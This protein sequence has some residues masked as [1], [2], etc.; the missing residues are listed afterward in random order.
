MTDV[1][2]SYSRKD[3]Q[4]VQVL[5]Q[6]L[7][8]S[9]YDAWVDW[10]NIPLTADWWE[11]IKA[12]IEGADTFIF[13]IS[14]DS[15][16]SKVCGQEIDHAVE[17][18][19]RLLPIVY[20]EG[21]D[22][23]LVRSALG[24]HNWLFFRDE[25]DFDTT[26]QLLVD[27]LNTDLAHVKTHTQLLVK[28]LEW[29]HKERN[30]DLLLRG[31]QLES[32]LS[33]ITANADKEPRLTQEQ[34]EYVAASSQTEKTSQEA[35][36][37]RQQQEL[38]R[39][40]RWLGL[41]GIAF[42]IAS[43]LGIL[44]FSQFRVAEA[45]RQEVE[46]REIET[47]ATSAEAQLNSNQGL[48]GLVYGL[49]AARKLE[50][51]NDVP[52]KTEYRVIAALQQALRKAPERNRIVGH[53]DH[54]WYAALSPD[55]QYIVSSGRDNIANLWTLDGKKVATFE[56]HTAPVSWVAISPDNQTFATASGDA[57]I[58]LWNQA[59]ELLKTLTKHD[60]SVRNVDFSPDGKQLVSA[61]IDGTI[62]LWDV[63]GN[64]LTSS[65][66]SDAVCHALFSPNGQSLLTS[67]CGPEAQLRKPSG[68]MI[69]TLLGH[70]SA[71]RRGV[72]SPDGQLIAT[73]SRTGVI[74][75]WNPQGDELASIQAHPQDMW[76]LSFS[77]DSQKI[78]S[79]G[80]DGSFKVWSIDGELL[81]SFDTT[82]AISSID[83][84]H[85]G[86]TLL[87]GDRGGAVR[88]WKPK[89]Q[90][91]RQN[92]VVQ[93][94]SFSPDG[95]TFV[96]ASGGDD[97]TVKLWTLEGTLLKM[98]QD[99]T[100]PVVWA[101][102]TPDGNAVTVGDGS[103]TA[104]TLAIENGEAIA[105]WAKDLTDI[106]MVSFSPDSKTMAR[107]SI[108][109]TVELRSTSGE[110]STSFTA[111]D[112]RI[113]EATFSP[114]GTKL[115][116]ASDDKTVKVWSMKGNLLV[117]LIGHQSPVRG[118]VFSPDGER[119]ASVSDDRTVKLWTLTGEELVT[120]RGHRSNVFTVAFSPDGQT[121]ASGSKD[122]TIRLWTTDGEELAIL[123][124]HDSAINS[125]SFSPDGRT[126]ASADENGKTLLW[127]L[128]FDD[129]LVQTCHE[130]R[131]YL[132][133]SVNLTKRDRALCNGVKRDW[134]AEG[135]TLARQGKLEA[136]VSKF[137]QALQHDA[138]LT[139]DPL[140]KA[141]QIAASIPLNQAE[142]YVANRDLSSATEAYKQ[143]LA[144][145]PELN[146]EPAVRAR[147]E[148]VRSLT[149]KMQTLVSEGLT[150]EA[151]IE[152]TISVFNQGREFD[153]NQT[154]QARIL[155]SI[156]WEG[157]LQG[158][159]SKL[160]DVCEEA[161]ALAPDHGGI[162][163]SRGLARALTGDTEGAISDFQYFIDWTPDDNWSI[164]EDVKK[165]RQQWIEALQRGENPFTPEVLRNLLHAE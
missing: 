164:G 111:H 29:Q 18:N 148:I 19:K 94:V 52:L 69:T 100:A 95:Q 41:V 62:K 127:N 121:I 92:A 124:G 79:S 60:G 118:V 75:L 59:G 162:I 125:L 74:K 155:N 8:N 106:T 33:W 21:F 85:D 158:Y 145:Y 2:I 131:D 88:I 48:D 68:E 113:W 129:L 122:E 47:L 15:I 31:S 115:A 12:G 83:V 109:G 146:F 39:Q 165:R 104:Q 116:T 7:A 151:K 134:L 17:N 20:R 36:I 49:Q 133:T 35:E 117:T 77:A 44:A 67:S 86:E 153:L 5:N 99:F 157:S 84:G 37:Q 144:V 51:L 137:E 130:L 3:E 13:V 96:T 32:I 72:F 102:F 66:A 135:E 123:K 126:L 154:V 78:Y 53:S 22:K 54:V 141:K 89:Q 70:T 27:A 34:R 14:P 150:N 10:E 1:F 149:Q 6:A 107:A 46:R 140:L 110:E 23:S 142:Q 132:A 43:G 25:D 163:D 50:Q 63:D 90:E 58:K 119:I 65:N 139:F 114:D 30:P 73:A 56:G 24:K 61:S 98:F 105:S 138:D 45:R 87:L 16:A 143:A 4:F 159:A 64:L 82:P 136:A 128:R 26:F 71:I 80:E 9:K 76:G 97:Q 57:T 28:A 108:K 40:R 161:V 91:F 11:E 55:E 81:Q 93:D 101:D 160:L 156:C 147:Q 103:G 42:V 112:G 120:L 152:E 38:H